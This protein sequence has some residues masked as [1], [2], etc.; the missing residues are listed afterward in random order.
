M[1]PTPTLRAAAIEK[2]AR[3]WHE[4]D[5]KFGQRDAATYELWVKMGEALALAAEPEEAKVERVELQLKS[6]TKGHEEYENRSGSMRLTVFGNL[7]PGEGPVVVEH[8]PLP[9]KVPDIVER[10]R[11]AECNARA[12]IHSAVTNGPNPEADLWREAAMEIERL[13]ADRAKGA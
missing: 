3:A 1:T 6:V 11:Q 5:G 2:A 10:I 7:P 13:R 12:G 4:A 9:P 8:R